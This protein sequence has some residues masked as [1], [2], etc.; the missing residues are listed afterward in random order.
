MRVTPTAIVALLVVVTGHEANGLPNASSTAP[1]P[2]PSPSKVVGFDPERQLISTSGK[3]AFMPPRP[4]DR[5]GPCPGLNALANHG[6][7]PRDGVGTVDDF[8]RA[9]NE[10]ML[11]LPSVQFQLVDVLNGLVLVYGM[12]V[13][14]AR[15]LATVG[16]VFAGDSV[17]WSIGGPPGGDL[18]PTLG[19][20]ERPRGLSGTHNHLYDTPQ[21]PNGYDISTLTE[22]R[23]QRWD[24]SVATNPN[25]FYGPFAGNIAQRAAYIF[26]YRFMSNH[27]A[28]FP[29][30]YLDG[31][32]LKSFFGV[33]GQSGNFSHSPGHERIPDDW[34]R[35]AM[36]DELDF[37]GLSTDSRY[38][39]DRYPKFNFLG[40]N[41]GKVDSFTRVNISDFTRGAYDDDTIGEGRNAACFAVDFLSLVAPS[42]FADVFEDVSRPM[43]MLREIQ[44]E[45][46]KECPAMDGVVRTMFDPFPGSMG[47]F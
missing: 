13:D 5:R 29:Q 8:V 47:Q 33:E 23:S 18:D 9:T 44:K 46:S 20:K 38:M 26:I 17:R 28:D 35:R 41:R 27:S 14:F 40:G 10:G 15:F 11:I 24:E 16:A 3:H 30:G 45:A 12:D 7:L 39:A 42:H 31:D 25:F 4:D 6:Y 36:G 21:G 43:A 1:S 22:F 34:Y 32:V 19:L 37:Q 2:S